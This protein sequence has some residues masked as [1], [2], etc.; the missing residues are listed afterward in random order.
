MR[1]NPT[2]VTSVVRSFLVGRRQYS[3]VHSSNG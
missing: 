1:R 2:A 3:L